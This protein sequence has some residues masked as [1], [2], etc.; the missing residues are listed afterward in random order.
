MIKLKILNSQSVQKLKEHEIRKVNNYLTHHWQD[1]VQAFT[2]NGR[3]AWMFKSGN[4]FF[5]TDR[6]KVK[7]T[8]IRELIEKGYS[9][10]GKRGYCRFTI[11]TVTKDDMISKM[12]REKEEAENLEREMDVYWSDKMVKK[13]GPPKSFMLMNSIKQEDIKMELINKL[14]K[15][16]RMGFCWKCKGEFL[17]IPAFK[18]THTCAHCGNQEMSLITLN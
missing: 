4:C 3:P 14:I 10:R 15:G 1:V 5:L 12:D 18:N 17:Y 16:F 2:K 7:E 13:M 11:W 8:S 9:E 6:G